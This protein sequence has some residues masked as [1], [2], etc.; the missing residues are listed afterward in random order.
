MA[1]TY[2]KTVK[3]PVAAG[4]PFP[5]LRTTDKEIADPVKVRL[6]DT[7]ISAVFAPKA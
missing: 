6:G 5:L 4:K 2:T 7:F 1:L 3:M